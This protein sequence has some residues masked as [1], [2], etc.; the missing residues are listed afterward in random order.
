MSIAFGAWRGQGTLLNGTL[1][2]D[3]RCSMKSTMGSA[4]EFHDIPSM[5]GTAQYAGVEYEELPVAVFTIR[6]CHS[7]FRG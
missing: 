1:S 7:L 6:V 2:K 4:G 3:H 5:S